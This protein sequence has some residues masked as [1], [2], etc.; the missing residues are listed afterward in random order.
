MTFSFT[1]RA[2]AI[3][4]PLALA[5]CAVQGS[6]APDD[7]ISR[8]RYVSGES[9]SLTLFTVK[10]TQSQNGAHSALL[11]D[12]SQRVLFDPAGTFEANVAPE[13]NDV[14]FGFTPAVERA[15]LSYHARAAYFVVIQKVSV[16]PSVAEQALSLVQTSGP[17]AK[18][19]CTRVTSAM[20]QKIPGFRRLGRT[21]FPDNLAADFGTLPGVMTTEYREQD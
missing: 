17:V 13:R 10:N 18:A 7:T 9:P 1:R 21:W 12:A 20:M 8:Y 2:F 15:Y 11:V 6:W 4:A 19:N 5:G 16:T 3:G 14:L